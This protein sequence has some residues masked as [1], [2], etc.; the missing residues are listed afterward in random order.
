MLQ[1][2]GSAQVRRERRFAAMDGLLSVAKARACV[3]L[4]E[5]ALH[6][7]L[8]PMEDP[9]PAWTLEGM[10]ENYS[11]LL[12]KTVRVQTAMLDERRSR[13]RRAAEQVGLTEMLQSDSFRAFAQAI[14]GQP[15]KRRFGMQVLCYG[16]GDYSGPH[17][18]HHPEEADA[19]NGYLDLHVSLPTRDVDHQWLVYEQGGHLSELASINVLGRVTA[20]RL[21]FWHY[22]TPLVAKPQRRAARRWVLLGTFLFKQRG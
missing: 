18:D 22:T 7:T 12:P 6:G 4:L 9:I 3:Q 19:R 15:L 13:S 21:P 8:E 14:A 16:P 1:G 20:Y 5:S 2:K 10:H 17:N 11:E